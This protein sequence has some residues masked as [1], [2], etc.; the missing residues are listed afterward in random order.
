MSLKS[1]N[2]R[3][4]IAGRSARARV[5]G[6]G[7]VEVMVA[8][9]IGLVLLLGATQVYVSSRKTYETNES[10]ARLQETARYAMSVIEPDVRTANY[11]GLLK[12]ASWVINQAS[13]TAAAS[14]T[15]TGA[16]L[17]TQCGN[18]FAIDLNT[19]IQGDNGGYT[20]GCA[21]W[22]AGAV[23]TSDTLTVRRASATVS[24]VDP[25]NTTVLRI[26]SSRT[27]GQ[28]VNDA[29]GCLVAPTGRVNDLV[30]HSYYVDRDSD[31]AAGQP[32]LRR[33]SLVNDPIDA[34]PFFR[35]DEI[36]NG[37]ED[38]QIQFG[39]DPAGNTG[40][41]TQYVD[42]IGPAT[43]A[44][45]QVVSVRIWLLVRSETPEVG[46]KDN[47]TYAYGGR[48]PA[49]GTT[50]DLNAAGAAA[51]AYKPGDGYHRLLVSRTIM[52]RNALGT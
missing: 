28:I 17:S 14:S 25:A 35:D 12:G 11:W 3:F 46:F 52:I 31:E 41:A 48:L 24:S 50:A 49:N 30:V 13:Q 27:D 16:A 43:L 22:G 47:R 15:L 6:M 2:M 23:A 18:N 39:I 37:V 42:A 20:L 34:A 40:T 7:L 36:V 26:C 4:N 21:A 9:A 10:V 32:S 29:S 1:T 5:R 51:L 44:S 38:M 8:M 19:N 33:W 45:A